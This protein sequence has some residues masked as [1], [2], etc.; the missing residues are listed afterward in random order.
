LS[1]NKATGPAGTT[2]SG[3]GVKEKVKSRSIQIGGSR[4]DLDST[5][6]DLENQWKDVTVL[7][8]ERFA[9]SATR[10]RGWKR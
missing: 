5:L 7:Y 3:G 9:S 1:R 8:F 10:K 4:T 2:S 6:S